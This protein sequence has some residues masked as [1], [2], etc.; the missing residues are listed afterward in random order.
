MRFLARQD[1]SVSLLTIAHRGARAYAPENTLAAFSKAK[2]LGSQMIELDVRMSLDGQL[3]VFHDEHLL[4]CT[5]AVRQFPLRDCYDIAAFTEAELT[6]LD[7]GSWFVDELAL[8]SSARM[9]YLQCLTDAETLAFI[10][11]EDRGCYRSGLV[12]IPTLRQALVQA[13]AQGLAV[14]IELKALAQLTDSLAMTRAVVALVVELGM[15]AQVLVSSFERDL[16]AE[17]RKQNADIALGVLTDELIANP[18]A[19]LQTLDAD[20]YNL[21]FSTNEQHDW[22]EV[23]R[24]IQALRAESYA[25]NVW[26]CNDPV[27]IRRLIDA[28]VTGIISDYPDRVV[29]ALNCHS[30]LE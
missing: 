16:L 6:A 22:T 28:G 9:S 8:P 17:A 15:Q 2:Q 14:N 5:D 4:R 29:A 3:M 21:G 12:K 23:T 24:Q 26:T 10:S 19:Y 13:H 30:A 20:A 25:V 18:V 1:T 27:L 11:P 7:A